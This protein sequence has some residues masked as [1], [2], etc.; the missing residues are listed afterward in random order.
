MAAMSS[1]VCSSAVAE[2]PADLGL[3]ALPPKAVV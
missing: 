3:N 2:R 1:S